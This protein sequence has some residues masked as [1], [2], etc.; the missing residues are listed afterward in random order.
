MNL[1]PDGPPIAAMM[2]YIVTHLNNNSEPVKL[3]TETIVPSNPPVQLPFNLKDKK[4]TKAIAEGK[5][6][7]DA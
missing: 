6:N 3:G 2:D 7:V 4:I 1:F 5:H